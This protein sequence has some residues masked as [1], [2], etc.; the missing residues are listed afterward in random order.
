MYLQYL[1]GIGMSEGGMGRGWMDGLVDRIEMEGARD[2]LDVELV[3]GI[4]LN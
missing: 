2:F 4:E 3:L 1:T